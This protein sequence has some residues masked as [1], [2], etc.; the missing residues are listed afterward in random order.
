[1]LGPLYSIGTNNTIVT[2]VSTTLQKQ[3]TNHY[4]TL[5]LLTQVA[6]LPLNFFLLIMGM[7]FQDAFLSHYLDQLVDITSRLVGL[8]CKLTLISFLK[9]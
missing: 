7:F 6:I 5:L 8:I 3:H 4:T 9:S 2:I 1:M